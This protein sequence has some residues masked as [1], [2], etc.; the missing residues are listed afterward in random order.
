MAL[1]D[2]SALYATDNPGVVQLSPADLPALETLYT[3]AYPGNW[4][5]PRMLETGCYYGVWHGGQIASVAGVHVYSPQYRVAAL[6]NIT[7]H[8]D[9]RGKGLCT[10]VTANL[11]RAL[12]SGP[13]DT[14]GLNVKADN[15]AAIHCYQNLGFVKAA[16]YEELMLEN[17]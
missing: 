10:A 14:I 8:P 4:F 1:K 16:E 12:L 11:C 7:T 9:H 6:G 5:D 2:H 3:A 15:H 13:V 17:H